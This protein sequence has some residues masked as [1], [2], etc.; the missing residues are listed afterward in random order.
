[1]SLLQVWVLLLVITQFCFQQGHYRLGNCREKL[2]R[3]DKALD[4]FSRGYELCTTEKD[5]LD[6]AEQIVQ[7]GIHLKGKVSIGLFQQLLTSENTNAHHMLISTCTMKI[8]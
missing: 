4:A 5:K 8:F 7:L 6:F 1:M 3:Y 2:K